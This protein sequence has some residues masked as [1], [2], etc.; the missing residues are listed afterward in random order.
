MNTLIALTFKHDKEGAEKALLRL[1]SMEREYLMDLK[2]AVVARR[3]EDGKV[4][5]AQSV[6]LIGLGVWEGAFWGSII[7]LL[8]TGPLGLLVGG[9]VGAGFGALMGSAGDYGI[10]DDFIKR[11]SQ[12]MQPCCSALFILVR[13]LPPERIV[14]SMEGLGGEVIR[15]SLGKDWEAR[16]EEAL[17]RR[18]LPP[19]AP[20]GA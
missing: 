4:K 3:R 9:G 1:R 15:T 7:G 8:F 16:L 6:N 2:D 5:L 13:H 17:A 14:E 19:A 11:L 12:D 10:D 18:D 20:P